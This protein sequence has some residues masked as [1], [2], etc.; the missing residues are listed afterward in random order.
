ML[1]DAHGASQ[2]IHTLVDWLDP[3]AQ[4]SQP[5][6]LAQTAAAQEVDS[7]V[8]MGCC[9]V[10]AQNSSDPRC[11]CL[12]P[13]FGRGRP[14]PFTCRQRPTGPGRQRRSPARRCAWTYKTI[15][16][17]SNPVANRVWD[18]GWTAHP[19][20]NTVIIHVTQVS[21]PSCF[22]VGA[23]A[24][25]PSTT[26][27]PKPPALLLIQGARWDGAGTVYTVDAGQGDNPRRQSRHGG[28]CFIPRP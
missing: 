22:K 19:D 14:G 18:T 15:S 1:G 21:A 12:V 10:D 5:P 16:N 4:H 3:R 24:I 13:F 8:L 25:C 20:P 11:G 7:A 27:E 9:R 28:A 23:T 2:R 6:L 17:P 26:G